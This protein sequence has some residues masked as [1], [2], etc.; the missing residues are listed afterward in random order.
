MGLIKKA[1]TYGL[2]F[3]IGAGVGTGITKCKMERNY[4]LIPKDALEKK[5]EREIEYIK[6]RVES[7]YKFIINDYGK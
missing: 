2:I 4:D 7:D 3:A 6:P 1:I 5:I